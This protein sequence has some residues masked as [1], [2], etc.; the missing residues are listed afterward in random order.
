MRS[1]S[2]SVCVGPYTIKSSIEDGRRCGSFTRQRAIK[3]FISLENLSGCARVGGGLSGI[4]R[5]A[6]NGL[7]SPSGGIPSAI[8]MSVMPNDHTSACCANQSY[9]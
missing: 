9:E 2:A 4:M 7:M 5:R 8:S 1:V 6:R 3:L